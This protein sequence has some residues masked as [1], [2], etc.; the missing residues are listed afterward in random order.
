MLSVLLRWGVKDSDLRRHSQQIYSLSHLTTLETPQVFVRFKP[1]EGFGP[2]T[3][4][5]QITRCYQL[6]YSGISNVLHNK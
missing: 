3:S 5:L 4:R 1:P 2:T 6:S